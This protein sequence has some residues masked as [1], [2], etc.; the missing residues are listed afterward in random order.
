MNNKK[1][2][3]LILSEKRD[4]IDANIRKPDPK[5]LVVMRLTNPDIIFDENDD[6]IFRSEDIKIGEYYIPTSSEDGNGEWLVYGPYPKY[7]YSI[8][9]NKS[10]LKEGTIVSH[11]A[12]PEDGELEG[13]SNRL[14]PIGSYK[15][16]SIDV[17]EENEENVYRALLHGAAFISQAMEEDKD[18]EKLY[19]ILCDLQ[20]CIDS[21]SKFIDG[22][23]VSKSKN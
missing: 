20:A 9:T 10:R 18:L 3:S 7:D 16:M 22:K 5:Q 11:W 19:I 13:W 8:L 1:E 6:N 14:N 4:W 12:I 15:K 2:I 17:D 21:N 23:F